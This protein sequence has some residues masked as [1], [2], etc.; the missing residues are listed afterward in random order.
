MI[1]LHGIYDHGKVRITDKDLPNIRACVEIR[2][3]SQQPG[4][5]DPGIK[6]ILGKYHFGKDL[7]QKKLRDIVYE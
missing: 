4:A 7:D 6:D 3:D 1:I 5:P 2:L